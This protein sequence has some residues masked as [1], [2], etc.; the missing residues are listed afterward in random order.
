MLDPEIWGRAFV[1]ASTTNRNSY[2]GA[3]ALTT[4]L[5][6]F[7][8]PL[9]VHSLLICLVLLMGPSPFTTNEVMGCGVLGGVFGVILA[10]YCLNSETVIL[11]VEFE[12]DG[13][14]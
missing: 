9:R 1:W 8:L 7:P 2:V 3:T 13:G 12:V 10:N 6:L 14:R 11:E 4:P 5:A